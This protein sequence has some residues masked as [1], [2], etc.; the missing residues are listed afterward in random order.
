LMLIEDR[1]LTVPTPILIISKLF[2][3]IGVIYGMVCTLYSIHTVLLEP[4]KN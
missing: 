2:L 4:P 1:N 3:G